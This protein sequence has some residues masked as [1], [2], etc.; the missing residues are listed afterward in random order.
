MPD[1]LR[2]VE[3]L[4]GHPYQLVLMDVQMPVM[5]G[6][7]AAARIRS[8]PDRGKAAVPIVAITANAM[9]GDREACLAAGMN[10]YLTKP[11]SAASLLDE[12]GRHAAPVSQAG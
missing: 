2:A 7:E 6:L 10:G 1:G 4:C 8:L 3:A 12:I 5:N 11:I 9:R